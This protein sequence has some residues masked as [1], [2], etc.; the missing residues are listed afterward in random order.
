M[1][2]GKFKKDKGEAAAPAAAAKDV[3]SA[4]AAAESAA[5]EQEAHLPW[6][7]RLLPLWI[8]LAMAGGI[9]IGY[10]VPGVGERLNV[11][12]IGEVSLPIALGLWVMMLP[13]LTKVRYE[14]L[15]ELL[16]HPEVLRHFAVSFFL[17]WI[18]GPA[19]MTALAWACLPDLPAFRSGVIMVGLARCIAM[20][21]I[22]NQVSVGGGGWWVV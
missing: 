14:L 1:A 7:D 10:F 2:F 17:N 5:A 8:L 11:A 16:A 22:W 20:V 13:V 12:N 9:L 4:A 3:D 18:V 19:L 15:H 21:L 6:L